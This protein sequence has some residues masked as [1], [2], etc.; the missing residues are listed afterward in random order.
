M[1][2]IS[3]P[4]IAVGDTVKYKGRHEWYYGIVTKVNRV[5][6]KIKLHDCESIVTVGKI[7]TRRDLDYLFRLLGD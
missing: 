3:P 6:M 1:A 4:K 5:N 2:T 7:Y